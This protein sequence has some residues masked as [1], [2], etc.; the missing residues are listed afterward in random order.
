MLMRL[1]LPRKKNHVKINYGYGE[2]GGI[3]LIF[4]SQTRELI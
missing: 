3:K 4:W 2:I 1:S